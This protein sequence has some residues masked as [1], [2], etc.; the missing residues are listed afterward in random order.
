MKTFT[1][2]TDNNISAFATPEAAAAAT[3]TPFDIAESKGTAE[4]VREADLTRRRARRGEGKRTHPYYWP[5]SWRWG[6]GGSR[7]QH[8]FE[9]GAVLSCLDTGSKN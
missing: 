5:S 6:I 7:E 9:T 2:D 8:G 1:I 3:T 4:A